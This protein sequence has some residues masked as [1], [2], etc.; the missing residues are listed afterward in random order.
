MRVELCDRRVL[1]A[2]R[3]VDGVTCL[4]IN[5]PLVVTA[6]GL[7][8][9][10]GPRGLVVIQEAPGVPALQGIS[11]AFREQPP[12]LP[13][14]KTWPV[15]LTI[16]EA[17]GRYLPRQ[18]Q[19]NLPR[20]AGPKDPDSVFAPLTIALYPSPAA[21]IGEGWAVVRATVVAQKPGEAQRRLPWAWL[22]VV[23]SGDEL[24]KSPPLALALADGRGEA[25]IAVRALPLSFG[26]AGSRR[27]DLPAVIEVVFDSHLQ[28]LPLDLTGQELPGA[29][30]G[31]LPDPSTLNGQAKH[32]RDGTSQV[33][34][35]VAGREQT[36]DLVVQLTERPP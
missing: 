11:T 2:V 25:L 9:T 32:L 5:A 20:A 1:G 35:L 21:P 36:A 33:L 26:E 13:N 31:Y 8:L 3:C 14:G 6:P 34:T 30:D 18:A 23:P 22:R 7:T 16:R 29:N 24:P 10:R 4:P 19:I 27:A 12:T 15:T 28:D 17:S